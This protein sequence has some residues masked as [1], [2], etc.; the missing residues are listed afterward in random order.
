M[1]KRLRVLVAGTGYFSQF[2]YDAWSRCP[3]VEVVGIASLDQTAA[4]AF[5]EKFPSAKVLDDVGKMIDEVAADLI[6]IV[7][8]PPT[9]LPF[10]E[11]AASKGLDVICQKPFCGTLEQAKE[12]TETAAQAGVTLLVHENFRFQ[13][14]YLKIKQELHRVGALYRTTFRLRPGDGQG[15]QAYL[16]RQPYF[17]QMEKFLIHETAIHHIDVARFFFGEPANVYADLAQLNPVISGEDSALVTLGYEHGHRVVVDGN[18]LSDHAA[19]NCRRTMGELMIEGENG[20]LTLN[21]DGE[22]FFRAHGSQNPERLS[23]EW[24][25][26]GFGGDCVFNFTRHA[27]DHFVNGTDAQTTAEDYLHNLVLEERVYTS[28]DEGRKIDV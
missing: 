3:E 28:A 25:D 22:V 15:P 17:Q 10:I 4:L 2:H 13:P 8:P 23:Y 9:H 18:R 11:L 26:I 12:A 21:G 1:A 14:W 20:V 24:N 16:E 5:A 27:V 19:E 7:T 6:D